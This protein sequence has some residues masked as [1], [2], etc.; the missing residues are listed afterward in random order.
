MLAANVLILNM[1]RSLIAYLASLVSMEG[2]IPGTP[3]Q[4]PGG[5]SPGDYMHT[6][7]AIHYTVE[8]GHAFSSTDST[9]HEYSRA[10]L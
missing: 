2:E 9:V 3:G 4:G 7:L 10:E 6:V 8:S 5:R 1:P